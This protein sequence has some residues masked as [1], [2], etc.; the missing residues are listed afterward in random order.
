MLFVSSKILL[1]NQKRDLEGMF[2]REEIKKAVWDC[3]NEKS[4]GPGGFTF[5]FL[6]DIWS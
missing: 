3:G 2:S 5:D 4:P 1:A 6:R